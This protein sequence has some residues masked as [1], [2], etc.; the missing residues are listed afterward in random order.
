MYI[1]IYLY[2]YSQKYTYIY[3]CIYI[4]I[5]IY[6]YIFIKF[7]KYI[8]ARPVSHQT[9]P[10]PGSWALLLCASAASHG[11]TPAGRGDNCPTSTPARPRQQRSRTCRQQL[12]GPS[13]AGWAR[14]RGHAHCRA[15]VGCPSLRAAPC[16]RQTPLPP[17]SAPTCGSPHTPPS[18]PASRCTG[19]TATAE[20]PC[21]DAYAHPLL[22]LAAW[23]Y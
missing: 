5:Y 1:H 10:A 11:G 23:Y 8:T 18:A 14:A 20:G 6:I 19:A 17:A 21:C 13:R 15:I 4:S 9:Q 12:P 2:I 3:I 7:C 16:H 22:A